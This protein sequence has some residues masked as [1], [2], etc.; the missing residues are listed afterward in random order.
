MPRTLPPVG[1][2]QL[3]DE[4]G[5]RC[6]AEGVERAALHGASV[7]QDLDVRPE[8]A[9]VPDVVGDEDRRTAE[10]PETIAALELHGP[11]PLQVELVSGP[12]FENGM[13][14]VT[15][16]LTGTSNKQ[17]VSAVVDFEYVDGGG[18]ALENVSHT[19]TG[20][21]D[22]ETNRTAPLVA[23][24]AMIE[25]ETHAAFAPEQT[26]SIRFTVT[27]AEFS[28]GSTWQASDE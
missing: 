16:R 18:Q 3:L 24:G 25:H 27:G 15:L 26:R 6:G 13:A 10:R 22:F 17:L 23:S 12:S 2:D 4:R 5:N 11:A 7:L 21:W 19:L 1:V 9:D 14:G 8:R 28:D 20:A